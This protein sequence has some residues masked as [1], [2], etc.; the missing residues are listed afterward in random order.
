[1]TEE[2]VNKKKLVW[3]DSEN[4]CGK[5][6][7]MPPAGGR[8]PELTSSSSCR[9]LQK[10]ESQLGTSTPL[11]NTYLQLHIHKVCS[12]PFSTKI[13]IRT[14][15]TGPVHQT[16]TSLIWSGIERLA[17]HLRMVSNRVAYSGGQTGDH[18]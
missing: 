13:S 6:K 3:D 7:L 11:Y 9:M 18:V 5:G 16:G 4:G 1:M 8:E 17:S 15:V 10:L 2:D 14:P 12:G